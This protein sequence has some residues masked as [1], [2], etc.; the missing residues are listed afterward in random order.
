MGLGAVMGSKNLKAIV[1]RGGKLP[2]VADQAT[3][4]R[5]NA[6]FAEDIPN[7]TLSS[8]QKDLPGFAVWVHD[9]GVD[10]SLAINNFRTAEFDALDAYAKPQW[11]AHYEGVAPCPGC[12]N[13]CMKIYDSSAMH[14]E[15]TGS[16]GPNI[17]TEDVPT[18]LG[19]NDVTIQLGMDPVSLGF[20]L[21][22]AMELVEEG[23]VTSQDTDGVELRFGDASATREMIER[24]AAPGIRRYPCRRLQACG[25]A[26]RP[27]SRALRPARQGPGDGPVRAA[28]PDQPGVGF[29]GGARRSALRHL[30][31]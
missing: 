8:W 22:F 7:N 25:G 14:Q 10:A 6:K 18:L 9:T 19:Y 5:I 16:M 11:S 4:D 1:L 29:R 26:Y 27:R 23:I 3:V 24:I 20:T 17:G 15:I 12:A 13:D 31:A 28:Q 21:S 2:P 30:R